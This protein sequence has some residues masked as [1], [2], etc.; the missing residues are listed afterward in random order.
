ME[1]AIHKT[2]HLLCVCVAKN[3]RA[4]ANKQ[5]EARKDQHWALEERT[6]GNRHL[7]KERKRA[8]F[9]VALPSEYPV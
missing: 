2:S 7:A 6:E 9:C 3:R 1:S 5:A 8:P 4:G